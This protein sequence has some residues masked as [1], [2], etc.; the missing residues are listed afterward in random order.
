MDSARHT[1]EAG[2]LP[3]PLVA[4]AAMALVTGT[5]VALW[6]LPAQASS[7]WASP[8]RTAMTDRRVMVEPAAAVR[9]RQPEITTPTGEASDPAAPGPSGDPP[10]GL[11]A[12]SSEEPSEE[13]SDGPPGNL[14]ERPP[15]GP[16][17]FVTFVD[18]V[19]HPKFDVPAP[20]HRTGAR[21]YTIGHLTA[22]SDGCTPKWDGALDDSRNPVA[23]R[24]A[25]LRAQGGQ[26]S[27]AFGGPSG[28]ELSATCGSETRLV[29]A[30]QQVLDAY[31]LTTIDFEVRDS[32]DTTAT[33]RRAAA[34]ATLQR[35][36]WHDGRPLTVTFT[37]P[38]TEA[39]L[40]V[41]DRDMVRATR[42]AGIEIRAVNLLVPFKPGVDGN[43]ARM[44]TTAK[45]AHSQ[46]GWALSTAGRSC[47][48][49][50]ALTPV[51]VSPQDLSVD[52]A[53]LLV[54]FQMKSGL[55]WL[56]VRGARPSD[57]VAR[58]LGTTQ[59]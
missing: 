3:R 4:L 45:A 50:I 27:L 31:G 28:R 1:R 41:T 14:A 57:S 9:A 55:A 5:G 51:L 22:G 48:Q 10:A 44:M 49:R 20:V 56:S 43:V 36:A 6:L 2:T 26:A 35:K 34:I 18:A 38:A 24:L 25:R 16:S 17:G 15:G 58:L 33:R 11:S 59:D 46:L 47:W 53:R 40:S 19:R 29:A 39:G 12:G 13:P 32:A 54:D 30:Y 21:W 42:D 23:D 8:A 7:E 37:L 52:R